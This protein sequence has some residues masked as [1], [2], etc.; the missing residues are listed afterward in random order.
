MSDEYDRDL[1]DDL[2]DVASAP[3]RA[4]DEAKNLKNTA[5]DIKDLSDRIKGG[6]EQG[7]AAGSQEPSASNTPSSTSMSEPETVGSETG[8]PSSAAN[9]GSASE[10]AAAGDDAAEM[11]L[12]SSMPNP[13]ET[14]AGSLGGGAGTGATAAG[15]EAAGA[16]SGGEAAGAVA[17][18]GEAAGA[19][20]A[21]GEAAGAAA[22]G[23][24][25]GAAAGEAAGAAAGGAAA[26]SVA[27]GAMA[28]ATAA[29]PETLGLS[30]VA[31]AAVVAATAGVN[32]IKKD[33]NEIENGEDSSSG[34][35]FG[36]C[37]LGLAAPIILLVL[38]AI[39]VAEPI[40]W[41]Y[42]KAVAIADGVAAGW[43]SFTDPD[44][45]EFFENVFGEDYNGEM[46]ASVREANAIDENSATLYIDIIDAAMEN[47][48]LVV[49]KENMTTTDKI[50]Q[51]TNGLF[52][53]DIFDDSAALKAFYDARFPYSTNS[54]LTIGNVNDLVE[55]LKSA[56]GNYY[57]NAEYTVCFDDVNY[58]EILSVFCQSDELAEDM[59]YSSFYDFMVSEDV[60]N[61]LL[62]MEYNEAVQTGTE[63]ETTTTLTPGSPELPPS[64]PSTGEIIMSNEVTET[65]TTT[66]TKTKGYVSA[67]VYPYGLRELYGVMEISP[68]GIYS[69]N[70]N[71]MNYEMLDYNEQ[72]L[73]TRLPDIDF[74]PSY[75]DERSHNSMVYNILN[76]CINYPDNVNLESSEVMFS[77]YND[78]SYP[79]GRSAYCYTES[80]I[81]DLEQDGASEWRYVNANLTLP[82]IPDGVSVIL[83]MPQYIN[84]GDYPGSDT[85][86]NVNR[87]GSDGKGS[88]IKEAGCT[89]CSYAMCAA[90]YTR[91]TMD[92]PSISWN[93]VT[94]NSFQG[95]AFL[96]VYGLTQTYSNTF[97][98]QYCVDAIT[99]GKPVIIQIRGGW[100][101]HGTVYHG[102]ANGHFLVLCGYD[103]SG[104]YVKDPG[105]RANNLI[106]FDA[107]QYVKL[108]S[109]RV[110]NGD[111]V[112][113]SVNTVAEG[114]SASEWFN[115]DGTST[116]T[117]TSTENTTD[118]STTTDDSSTT[119]GK[120]GNTDPKMDYDT[121]KDMKEQFNH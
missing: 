74:G 30:Y 28:A 106:P 78:Y 103:S 67:T 104:F 41:I 6:K 101:Y 84:Q 115:E 44:K 92:Q 46:Y 36:C 82:S 87:R 100:V 90:Y 94:A 111:N 22:G 53:F 69:R 114:A 17:A 112:Y 66:T 119:D 99:V 113:Y 105:R 85:N 120:T 75:S 9:T 18:G 108:E 48:I 19:A 58:A 39:L 33:I 88:T 91:Q 65:T 80:D 102:T 57:Q 72:Y 89:D 13:A 116:E 1:D 37:L 47:S 25:A 5:D 29:A 20:A 8:V 15:G 40:I 93:Y 109:M 43:E 81:C 34:S 60:A 73:R 97:N 27:G 62:E 107:F 52:G 12:A 68:L 117:G 2:G 26:G 79:T 51:F 14:Q 3:K 121:M 21:G 11:A 98:I 45:A 38:G 55:S 56:G 10:A 63:E 42:N 83:D 77:T 23:A 49:A 7:D 96:S 50:N 70:E 59:S 24:A 71:F 32:A 16:A 64:L 4:Y 35:S 95:P 61:I 54:S 118:S 86:F 110:I 31:A 76:D